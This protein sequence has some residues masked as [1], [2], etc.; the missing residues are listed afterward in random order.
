[1]AESARPRRALAR[2]LTI[3]SV[4]AATIVVTIVL[5]AE[6]GIDPTGIGSALGLTAM[7]EIKMELAREAE[8]D[9]APRASAFRPD[10]GTMFDSIEVVLP[11]GEGRE[12][13]LAM[14]KDGVATYRW[15]AAGGVVNYDMHADAPAIRYHG[16]AKGSAVRA[17][18]GTLTAAFDGQHG[19]FWRNRG[20]DTV[21]VTLRASGHY[22]ELKRLP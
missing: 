4:A 18:S 12:V 7:G 9:E 1:M 17:D 10:A 16:Y 22:T 11:P 21:V 20:G 5:P 6:R 19:W 15:T 13:K 14:S 2:S 3:L 8:A